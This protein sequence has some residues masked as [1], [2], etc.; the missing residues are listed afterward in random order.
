LIEDGLRRVVSALAAASRPAQ[1][2]SLNSTIG[3]D[4][5]VAFADLSLDAAKGLGRRRGTTINDVV[6]A[7][8]ALAIGSH[9]R[10]RGESQ[11]W[12]RA[13][14][15]VSTRQAD[16]GAELGNRISVMFVELPIGERDPCAA[17]D[18]VCRQTRELKRSESADGLDAIL[19][20]AGAMPTMIR[21]AAAWVMT[22]PQTFG[23]VVSNIPGPGE[24]LYLLG[25]RVRAAYPAV[26]LAQG[27]GLSVGVLSYCGTLHVGLYADPNVV[28]DPLELAAE[29]SRSFDALRF[30]LMPQPPASTPPRPTPAGPGSLR[31]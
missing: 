29:F 16:R 9:L 21:D 31:V 27:H 1:A 24:P 10:H 15:P 22:R 17:L 2:T 14:V 19:R 11:P 6:L 30:A 3:P 5:A 13:F 20:A 7:T 25:R 18:E 8:S 28:G 4:R 12:L 26:P 23:A